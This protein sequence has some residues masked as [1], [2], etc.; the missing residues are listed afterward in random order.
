MITDYIVKYFVVFGLSTFIVILLTPLFIKLA[1]R[2][3]LMDE[4]SERCIH[5]KITPLG[6]GVVVFI[7]FNISCYVLYRFFWGN[8]SG[9]LDIV[10]W[11]SFFLASCILLVVG[12]IDDR[13][14]M[15]PLIKLAGQA[16]ACATLYFLSDYQLNVLGID[17]GFW[18]GL[19]FVLIWT[20][21][22]INAF[23][24][25]D[26]LDGLCSGLAMISAI[27]LSVIFILRS[28]PGDA[29]VCLALIG[30]CIGFLVFNFYPAKVFLGDTGSMFLGFALAS[31]SLHAGGKGSFF[32]ILAAPFF[33][34]GVP[35]T[36][37]LLAIWRRSIRKT[38]A[39]QK[40]LPAIHIMKP[41]KEHLHHRLLDYGLKQHHV[42]LV[43]YAVNILIVA[44]GLMFMVINELA[45][46]FF[47][48]IFIIT[49]YI[50]VKYV[51]QIEL[52]E[53]HK[54]LVSTDKTPALTRFSILFYVAFD[55][56]WMLVSVLLANYIVY[57][58]IPIRTT[59]EWIARISLWEMPTFTLLFFSKAYFKIWQSSSFR[60]YLFLSIAVLVGS[61]ISLAL[62]IL[63]TTD[64]NLLIANKV[65]V[66]SLISLI[67]IAG[68]R[69]SYHFI[70]EWSID[71]INNHDSI[72]NILI[73]GAGAHGG[74]YLR[75]RYLNYANE[76][77]SIN[78]IGFIDDDILLRNQYIYGK[79]VFG[80]IM[81]L[82]Q[83]ILKHHIKEIILTTDVSSDNLY[84]LKEIA[85]KYHINLIKW[86]T[87]YTPIV[88]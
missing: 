4:P 53:T 12:L 51:L 72:R 35:V 88:V 39:K 20:V 22:I 7:A 34:A 56:F 76:L 2:M 66:F 83:I 58:E 78:I 86:H 23:N 37:T 48:I 16:T 5:K 57:G 60:D 1:P 30:A 49:L 43:L 32:V 11:R 13:F 18:G 24:L 14:G 21:A 84:K 79:V 9:L 74:L 54:L 85:R 73:Y 25:I 46:G 67:G 82:E 64:E 61:V 10:W 8:F 69:I 44:I 52:W 70:R 65:I 42:A 17:F 80:G 29:L 59:A 45:T 87:L 19:F 40:G 27:G 55:L 75:E 50:L 71:H 3:G 28:S 41:D 33:I 63:L 47:L 81:D 38:L 36:D 15:S 77:G 68:I 62:F 6:G 26:G 31:I